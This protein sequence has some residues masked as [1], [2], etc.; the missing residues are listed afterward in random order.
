[1]T[2]PKPTTPKPVAPQPPVTT[3]QY[4]KTITR[5]CHLVRSS[6]TDQY[7]FD[8]KTLKNEGRHIANNVRA[9]LPADRAGL[10]DGDFILQV[11]GESLEGME[12]DAVV[13][14]ISSN[15]TQVDLLVVGDIN[16]YMANRKEEARPPVST[17]LPVEHDEVNIDLRLPGSSDSSIM[18]ISFFFLLVL[19]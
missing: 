18:S 14:K 10:R 15:P 11:N 1:V 16:A 13:N 8:F 2:A 12:H 6:R 17:R 19:S 3:E 7:G 5:F 4:D 9:G